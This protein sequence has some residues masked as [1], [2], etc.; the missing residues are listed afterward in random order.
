LFNKVN[1][2]SSSVKDKVENISFDLDYIEKINFLLSNWIKEKKYLDLESST[3]SL[4]KDIDLPHHHVTYFFNNVNDE[5]YIE[6]RSRLRVGYAM[7]LINSEKGYVKTIERLGKESG[8]KSYATF[9]K[10]FKL[11]TGKLPKDYVADLKL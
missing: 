5:K 7:S 3:F 2:S 10:S 4:S 6:W 8:F 9:I 1:E 11:V